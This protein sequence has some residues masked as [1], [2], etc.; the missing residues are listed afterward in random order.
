[1]E[2][3]ASIEIQW[4]LKNKASYEYSKELPLE[5][6]APT[7]SLKRGEVSRSFPLFAN[8]LVDLEKSFQCVFLGA[9][10]L[11]CC[12]SFLLSLLLPTGNSGSFLF[13]FYLTS[14]YTLIYPVHTMSGHRVKGSFLCWELER[15]SS[16]TQS[17]LVFQV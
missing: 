9:T 13:C 2:L 3:Q 7:H 16:P 1:M 14:L 8:L 10:H 6:S 4:H 12:L 15:S 17:A 5:G 11:F